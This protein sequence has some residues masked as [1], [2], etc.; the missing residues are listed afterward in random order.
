MDIEYM[1]NLVFYAVAL[2]MGVVTVILSILG[3]T[4]SIILLA[5]GVA[6]LGLAG[7]MKLDKKE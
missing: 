4:T 2:A 5:I 7:L 1:L 6:V 3:Q